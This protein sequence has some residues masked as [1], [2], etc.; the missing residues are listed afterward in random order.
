MKTIGKVDDQIVLNDQ[1]SF[2]K[3]CFSVSL[4][5]LAEKDASNAIGRFLDLVL[6]D[7]APARNYVAVKTNEMLYFQKWTV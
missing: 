1:V 5:E 3:E 2:F 7:L 6:L 4:N